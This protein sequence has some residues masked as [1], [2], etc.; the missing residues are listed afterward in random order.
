MSVAAGVLMLPRTTIGKK[1]IMAVTGLIWVGYVV[2]HMYGNLKL[3]MGQE[4]FNVYAE[5]LRTLGAPVFGHGHLLFIARIGLIG[6]LLLHVWAAV[7]LTARARAARPRGYELKKSVQAT[8]ASLYMRWGGVAILFFILYHLAH[9]TWGVPGLSSSFVRGDPYSN[10]VNS[11]ASGPAIF[12]YYIA[13]LALGLHLYHGVWSM[14]Q[15]LG[16]NNKAYSPLIRIVA[17]LLAIVVPV[18]FAIPPLA[19][20]LGYVTLG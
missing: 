6:S 18:G 7:A 4:Y 14:F 12:L 15:T 17:L 19:V 8:F 5:G 16:L 13:L 3:F 10:V 9:L 2:V 1:V 20:L 11:F